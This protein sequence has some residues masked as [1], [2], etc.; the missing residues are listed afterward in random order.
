MADML[1]TARWR[2]SGSTVYGTTSWMMGSL[3]EWNTAVA[4]TPTKMMGTV[5]WSVTATMARPSAGRLSSAANSALIR[6]RQKRSPSTPATGD[7]M[8]LGPS[9]TAPRAPTSIALPDSWYTRNPAATSC[10]HAPSPAMNRATITRRK[11]ATAQ[12]LPGEACLLT[13]RVGSP[14]GG[15][16]RP[17]APW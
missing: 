12:G 11:G 17:R 4:A 2:M 3:S 5:R 1:A 13:P 15:R 6:R 8:R 9:A 10:I 14:P 16:R 7:P